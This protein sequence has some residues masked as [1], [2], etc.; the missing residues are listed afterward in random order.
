MFNK[1]I[2]EFGQEGGESREGMST[3]SVNE[4]EMLECIVNRG[5]LTPGECWSDDC[6]MDFSECS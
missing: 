4:S 1:V 3:I 2:R 6:L 5:D